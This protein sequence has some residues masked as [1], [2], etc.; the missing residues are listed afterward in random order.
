MSIDALDPSVTEALRAWRMQHSAGIAVTDTL[1]TCAPL[2]SF[3]SGRDCFLEA[4]E[5][6]GEGRDIGE[7]LN[8]L[9]PLL[10]E[11]ERETIA[12]GWRSG[13][14]EPVMDAV[15]RQREL[16]AA[17]RRAIKSR[18]M[19]PMI[20]LV[21]AS[22]IGPL[23]GFIAGG[24]MQTYAV[25]AF[26]PLLIAFILWKVFFG[27]MSRARTRAAAHGNVAPATI[28]DRLLLAMPV[29]QNVE[30]NRNLAEL[31]TYLSNLIGAGIMMSQAL[32]T[33]ARALSNGVYRE[34]IEKCSTLTADGNLL[35][36]GLTDGKLWPREYVQAIDVGEKT[37][38][39]D[40]TLA[41]M[42]GIY[43]DSYLRAV[44]AFA[45]WI[46]RV[47]YGIISLIIIYYI[48]SMLGVLAGFYNAAGI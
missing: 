10:S 31:A 40:E 18:M 26:G 2:C 8:A 35:S 34:A 11:A 14:V 44:E 4:S 25:K 32:K 30:R 9:A 39:L 27:M 33:C 23:P 16:W 38:K 20:V 1:A 42:A 24:D 19:M 5:R 21:M 12:A 17:S 46:P 28:Y 47:I 43:R 15:I 45:E 6:A 29:V 7:L 36:T 37:G 48:F 3:K 22:L 13:R 41:R